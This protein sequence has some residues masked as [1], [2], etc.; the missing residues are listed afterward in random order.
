M[1]AGRW[2]VLAR[3]GW[4]GTRDHLRLWAQMVGKTR[5]A[6][7]PHEN[8]SWGAALYV[9][10]RGLTTGPMPGPD[11]A[12]DLAFDL[13]GHELVAR[14]SG[15]LVLA[16]PLRSGTVADFYEAYLELLDDIGV[17][18][19][20][21]PRPVES[22]ESIP[23]PDDTLDRPY[24]AAWAEAF[25]AALVEADRLFRRFRAEFIGKASPVHFFWGA[26]DLAVTRFSGRT[27]PKHPGGIP[28]C[29]DRVMWDAY[30]HEVSSAGFWPGMGG[31]SQAAF[32]S[33]AY[34]VPEGFADA[35]VR[36]DAAGYSTAMGE[37]LLPYADVRAADDPDDMVLSFL[38]S[39]YDAAADLA[40]WS[41]GELERGVEEEPSIGTRPPAEQ[42]SAPM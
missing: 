29:P 12:F 9:N 26:M 7:S 13:L 20:I 22:M 5:L 17:H 35:A 32:Y 27:A 37:F 40:E 4:E 2:P 1:A 21:Y 24:D 14:T 10:A 11:G 18:P 16:L 36:P 31:D 30:S 34:P 3:A 19:H 8:H 15:G 28:N 25:F 39:T 33:Y 42:P 23:F 41:R 6:L 38:A